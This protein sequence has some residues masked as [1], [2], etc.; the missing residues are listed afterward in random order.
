M[1]LIS[2]GR[3]YYIHTPLYGGGGAMRGGFD[4][5][6]MRFWFFVRERRSQERSRGGLSGDVNATVVRL[7]SC[8]NYNLN[9]HE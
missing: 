8:T 5:L 6:I 2:H 1:V 4:V 7:E 3:I 9:S